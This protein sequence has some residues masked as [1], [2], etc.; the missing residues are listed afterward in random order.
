[1]KWTYWICF[2]LTV[3]QNDDLAS[4]STDTTIQ[5]W[6]PINGTLI[7]TLNGLTHWANAL[8]VLQN[9]DNASG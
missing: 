5:I 3:L 2:A 8:T 9:G 7:R 1:M 4:G 6:N